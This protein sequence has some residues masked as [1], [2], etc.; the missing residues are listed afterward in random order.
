MCTKENNTTAVS[1]GKNNKTSVFMIE[2]Q[3]RMVFDHKKRYVDITRQD[4]T[5]EGLVK[6][7]LFILNQNLCNIYCT[8]D[9]SSSGSQAII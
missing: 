9:K 8:V 2:R 5:E 7:F 3:K 6:S 4:G 1:L